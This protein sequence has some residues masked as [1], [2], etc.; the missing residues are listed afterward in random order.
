MYS[1][2]YTPALL[3]MAVLAMPV[4]DASAQ[5]T[6]IGGGTVVEVT[7]EPLRDGKPPRD[8]RC[9]ERVKVISGKPISVQTFT[10]KRKEL[11]PGDEVCIT[12]S[13]E[14]TTVS[15][16]LAPSPGNPPS[17]GT[18]PPCVSGCNGNSGI[19]IR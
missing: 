15:A 17:T 16:A 12:P 3:V 1:P 10:G 11:A 19:Q 8:V 4:V 14:L 18:T 2:R 13:G 5:Q 7:V 6:S 9:V